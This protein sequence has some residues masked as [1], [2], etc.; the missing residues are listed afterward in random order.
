M[1]GALIITDETQKK[2]DALIRNAQ[3][4]PYTMDDLLDI[5]NGAMIPPGDEPDF[6]IEI[7]VGYRVVYTIEHQVDR[8]FIHMSI[9]VAGKNKLPDPIVVGII[10]Q[11]FHVENE[12]PDCIISIEHFAPEH[13]AV[14]IHAE[15]S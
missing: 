14:S 12:L 2:I 3:L 6:R 10:L 15:I 5:K 11:L 7:P 4:R 1:G 9:S 13:Q 8:K